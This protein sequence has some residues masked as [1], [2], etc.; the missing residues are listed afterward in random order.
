MKIKNKKT[1]TFLKIPIDAMTVQIVA[2][3][4]EIVKK[5]RNQDKK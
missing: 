5:R 1:L 3:I 2:D 4:Q